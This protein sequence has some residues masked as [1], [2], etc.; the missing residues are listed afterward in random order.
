MRHPPQW[1]MFP[2]RLR[3]HC[4]WFAEPLFRKLN[5]WA[6]GM[7][8]LRKLHIEKIQYRRNE[9]QFAGYEF[10]VVMLMELTPCRL[11]CSYRCIGSGWPLRL[12]FTLPGLVWSR[13]RKHQTLRNFDCW[14]SC[15]WRLESSGCSLVLVVCQFWTFRSVLFH[16]VQPSGQ[17]MYRQFNL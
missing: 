14:T 13:E 9:L 6:W 7:G 4:L 2:G 10:L 15:N 5:G 8:G 11:I 17:Y 12:Q 1:Q 3:P 16:P